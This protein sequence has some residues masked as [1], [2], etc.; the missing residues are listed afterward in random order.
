MD[1]DSYRKIT[2]LQNSLGNVVLLQ[3]VILVIKPY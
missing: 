2:A 3:V 1:L